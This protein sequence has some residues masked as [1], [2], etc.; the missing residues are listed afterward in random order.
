MKEPDAECGDASCFDALWTES[1]PVARE[2]CCIVG[3]LAV[4]GRPAEEGGIAC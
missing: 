4:W 2:I 1:R 3:G